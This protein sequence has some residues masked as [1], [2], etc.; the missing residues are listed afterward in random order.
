VRSGATEAE[1][2]AEFLKRHNAARSSVGRLLL[3]MA[4]FDFVAHSTAERVFQ[5]MIPIVMFFVGLALFLGAPVAVWVSGIDLL[6]AILRVFGYFVMGIVSLFVYVAIR[7]NR[8][9]LLDNKKHRQRLVANLW[10]ANEG[11]DDEIQRGRNRRIRTLW[12][13]AVFRPSRKS[14][15]AHRKGA[16]SV[17]CVAGGA[18]DGRRHLDK[19]QSRRMVPVVAQV[20]L[21][22]ASKPMRGR[23]Q[24]CTQSGSGMTVPSG[25]SGT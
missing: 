6:G 3:S 22:Q 1:L 11:G 23:S 14:N 2:A 7:F 9:L 15:P 12:A 24:S 20:G 19:S 8:K 4:D 13:V 21:S 17:L 5:W 18:S 25:M 10:L 16:E